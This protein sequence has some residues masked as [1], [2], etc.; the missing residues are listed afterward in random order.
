MDRLNFRTLTDF[1]LSFL[2]GRGFCFFFVLIVGAPFLLAG[3]CLLA[4]GVFEACGFPPRVSL[5]TTD[6]VVFFLASLL[7][8]SFLN[9]RCV[10]PDFASIA[11]PFETLAEA[12]RTAG[13]H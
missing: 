9:G 7:L 10:L 1:L 11:T 3:V 8:F 13:L 4:A 12:L 6:L 2:A 5:L